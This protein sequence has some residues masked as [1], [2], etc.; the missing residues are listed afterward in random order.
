MV[1]LVKMGRALKR[2]QVCDVWR[3]NMAMVWRDLFYDSKMLDT[4]W[5]PARLWIDCI[6]SRVQVC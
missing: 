4:M 5:L 1:S 6:I 3:L 2:D